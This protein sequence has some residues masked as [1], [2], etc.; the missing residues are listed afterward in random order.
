MAKDLKNYDL[1]CNELND[2]KVLSKEEEKELFERYY[3]GD[4]SACFELIESN[5]KL[6]RKLVGKYKNLN[7]SLGDLTQ[8][9]S[10]YLFTIIDNFD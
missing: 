6:I 10:L 2:I 5:L 7:I 9:L 3:A 1:Y 8:D 4:I